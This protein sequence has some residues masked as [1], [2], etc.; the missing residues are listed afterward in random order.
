[1]PKQINHAPLLFDDMEQ[2]DWEMTPLG[3]AKKSDK[4]IRRNPSHLNTDEAPA[5]LNKAIKLPVPDF[6]DPHRKLTCLE[7][8]FP[9]AQINALSNLEGNAG[10]PIY[11]MSKWWARRRSSIFRSLLIAAATEEPEENETAAKKVWDHYY[12]NHQKAES[13]KNLKVLDCFMGG[14]TTLVEGSRLGMQM[15]GVDLNP[16]AWFVTKNELACSDPEQVK[17]F[18]SQIE[19]HVKPKIQPFYTTTCPR[20]HQGKWIDTISGEIADIDPIDLSPEL[21]YRYRWE[22]P[23][24]IYTFWA[25]H[26]P[27]QSHLGSK[28]CSHRT[29]VF[30]NPVIAQKSLSTSYLEI[31]CPHCGTTFHAELGETRMAPGVERIIAKEEPFFTEISQSFSQYLK[32]YESGTKDEK[33]E[34]VLKLL[35]LVKTENGLKCPKCNNFAGK[36]IH[37]L[38]T[39]HNDND[40]KKKKKD[41]NI[42]SKKVQMFLLI[43]PDW[44][45]GESGLYENGDELG[46]Y[47][48][49]NPKTTIDW[50]SKRLEK[51]K[52]VEYRGEELTPLLTSKDN[53]SIDTQKGTSLRKAHFTCGKCGRENN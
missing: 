17:D 41:F 36:R 26:G 10:K 38:L 46:G 49:A 39:H 5:N 31:V 30:S 52:F 23:E 1:M 34:R 47:A 51:L 22:G 19:K 12:C 27:C 15:T 35:E 21:R 20:G 18:F 14:G 33:A 32:N 2:T 43:H 24:V 28:T 40:S 44:F 53:I 37:E 16:V 4:T 6:S 48:G 29:P 11:Q 13:F 3:K 25:K 9:I 45:S 50:Y 42:K 8:D 7:V